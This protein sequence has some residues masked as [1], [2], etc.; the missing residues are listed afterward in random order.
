MTEIMRENLLNE[1]ERRFNVPPDGQNIISFS[2]TLDIGMIG[3]SEGKNF[4]EYS[5]FSEGI[6]SRIEDILAIEAW[7][8]FLPQEMMDY[9]DVD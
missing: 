4:D 3:G 5:T 9:F 2:D 1:S 6:S 7:S 8:D